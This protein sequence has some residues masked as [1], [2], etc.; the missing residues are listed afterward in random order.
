MKEL[1]IIGAGSYGREIYNLALES[2]GYGDV[3]SIKGF[4]DNLYDEVGYENY[5]PI[6]GKVEDYSPQPD[7]VFVCAIMDVEVKRKYI[8]IVL[9]K[10]GNFINLIHK[11]SRI[12]QNTTI[13][14]GCIICDN[15][16]ISCDVTIGDFV[17]IQTMSVVGHDCEI[18]DYSHLNCF[19]FLGG[20]CKVGEMSTINTGAILLPGKKVG[21]HGLVGAGSVVLKSVKD[22]Q[23]V[24]GY[25]ANEIKI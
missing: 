6:L 21:Y 20:K 23:T 9:E 3:F 17:T 5:P 12:W 22:G 14:K 8:D 13:G 7:D 16:S 25:P 15:V 11:A 4:I 24:F 1:V 2:Q 18:G 10:G 19:S